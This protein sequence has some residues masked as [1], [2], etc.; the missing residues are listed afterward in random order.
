VLTI[1]GGR[2]TQLGYLTVI[3]FCL[4]LWLFGWIETAWVLIMLPA[5]LLLLRAGRRAASG[6]PGGAPAMLFGMHER[7]PVG[8]R[9]GV[10][11]AW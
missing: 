6:H 8:T 1:S 2:K 7:M 4:A 10:A 9:S 11:S 3:A 5:V